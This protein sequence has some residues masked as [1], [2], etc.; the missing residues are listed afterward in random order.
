MRA[1]LLEGYGG[2]E[3]LRYVED[4]P[5]PEIRENEVLIRVKAVALNHLDIWV[6]AKVI[7]E[8]VAHLIVILPFE[9][10]FYKRYARAAL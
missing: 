9:V 10:E 7:S 3:K 1:V 6:R 2:V 8:L 4:F 5:K